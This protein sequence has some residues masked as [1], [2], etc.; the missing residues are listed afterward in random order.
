[1]KTKPSSH[2]AHFIH[3]PYNEQI[4]AALQVFSR[5]TPVPGLESR[6]ASRLADARRSSSRSRV[7]RFR[8]AGNRRVEILRRLSFGAMA[9]A[10]GGAIVFGSVEHSHRRPVP[11]VSRVIHGGGGLSTAG[12]MHVPLGATPQAAE[13]NP[14]APRNPPHGRAVLSPNHGRHADGA[15]V[16]RSPYT[17]AEPQ[18]PAASSAPQQ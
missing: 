15:A 7:L 17:A 4:D 16:P 5:A 13:I 18:Q 12:A 9:A 10:A 3:S 6:I 14:A 2:S 8:G 11:Q 1:M